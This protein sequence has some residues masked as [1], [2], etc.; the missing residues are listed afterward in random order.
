MPVASQSGACLSD[1]AS[2]R[3]ISKGLQGLSLAV[4]MSC[5]LTS[6]YRNSRPSHSPAGMVALVTIATVAI[7][8]IYYASAEEDCSA[9]NSCPID[10]PVSPPEQQIMLRF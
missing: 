5:M 8:M 6:C 3:R 7:A 10:D 1:A 2:P 4:L 9:I